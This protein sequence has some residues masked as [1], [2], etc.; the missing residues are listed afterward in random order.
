MNT[1]GH[2]LIDARLKRKVDDRKQG[3]RVRVAGLPNSRPLARRLKRKV[4]S[5]GK[6]LRRLIKAPKRKGTKDILMSTSTKVEGEFSPRAS[7]EED[8]SE[9]DSSDLIN[10]A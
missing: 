6:L 5:L 1:S 8:S 7:K 3:K 2:K 9:E 4:R 10:K